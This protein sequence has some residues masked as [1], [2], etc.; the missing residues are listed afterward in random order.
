MVEASADIKA[1]RSEVE[2]DL[3]K[4]TPLAV[5]EALCWQIKMMRDART[6]IEG[7][8]VIVRDSRNNAVE[9]PAIETERAAMRV[10]SE[11]MMLWGKE[12]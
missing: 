11:M 12:V 9:H 2:Q 1:I 5:V 10:V 7:D 8:G 6:L 3:R 4:E